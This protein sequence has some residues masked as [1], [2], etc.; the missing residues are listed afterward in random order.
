MSSK[1]PL[2]RPCSLFTC[3]PSWKRSSTHSQGMIVLLCLQARD[4]ERRKEQEVGAAILQQQLVERQAQR[5]REEE[6]RDQV[7]THL[8][9]LVLLRAWGSQLG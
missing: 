9:C 2:G 8:H 3:L 7:S 6:L 5:I 1:S 4:V